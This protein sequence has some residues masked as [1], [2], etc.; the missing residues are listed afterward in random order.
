MIQNENIK[1]IYCI[2]A[3][4]CQLGIMCRNNI[5]GKTEK[6]HFHIYNNNDKEKVIGDICKEYSSSYI[7]DNFS[8]T[9][10]ENAS[11]KEKLLLMMTATM[12]DYQYL[13][14]IILLISE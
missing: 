7:V 4:Y 2:E 3:K 9:F 13:K 5:F 12:T 11:I 1:N 14:K 10:P 6:V 8:V